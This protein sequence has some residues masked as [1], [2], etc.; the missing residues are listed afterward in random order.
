MKKSVI[1][2]S[3]IIVMTLTLLLTGCSCKHE[4]AEAS[5]E[6]AKTCNLC[7]EVEGEALG[8]SWTEAN[9]EAAKTCSTCGLTDGEPLAHTW[10]E[11]TCAA[12]KTCSVCK[13]TEGETLEHNLTEANY[14][15]AST[16]AICGVTEGEPLTPDFVAH[17]MECK[18]Q[19]NV[20]NETTTYCDVDPEYN[21]TGTLTFTDYAVFVS[22]E[23]HEAREGYVWQAVSMV[24]VFND[25]NA[26]N[27]GVALSASTSDYYKIS[28]SSAPSGDGYE[29]TMVNFYG[30]EYEKWIDYSLEGGWDRETKTLTATFRLY[31]SVPVGYDGNIVGA[32]DKLNGYTDQ[33]NQYLYDIYNENC[34]F[35]RLPPAVIE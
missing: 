10:K 11:A 27:H 21:T 6:A 33:A 4:W 7:G 26:W 13:A 22:D 16:C 31:F 12:P 18:A 24:Y 23:V 28:R 9:C 30:V 29:K 19:L 25:D 17:G 5:C 2:K 1:A 20:P 14:Q 3:I 32:Y 8:H 15:E 35:F 34:I